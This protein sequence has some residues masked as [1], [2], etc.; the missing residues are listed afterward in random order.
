MTG[1]VSI[2][3]D[4]ALAAALAHPAQG[5]A[6]ALTGP[7][8]TGKSFALLQRARMLAAALPAGA[9]LL[10]APGDAGVARLR[11]ELAREPGGVAAESLAG[12]A[13]SILREARP[14]V[15]LDL[16]D[17]ATAATLFEEASG[18]LFSLEWPELATAEIDPE[19]TGL[20][21][22]QR[23]AASAFRL[24]A[25][26]R[27]ALVS[28]DAFKTSGLRGAT[29]FYGRPPNFASSEL[30]LDTAAKYRDSLRVSPAELDR[31][32]SREVDLVL[33][34]TRLYEGYIAALAERRVVTANDAIYDAAFLLH[35]RADL[36]EALRRRFPCA[37]IDDAQDL[38][39]AQLGLLSAIYGDRLTGVTLAG[40]AAQATRGF[41]AGAR[42][43][44]IFKVAAATITFS[45]NRRNGAA[46][47]R[48]AA[49]GLD[50]LSRGDLRGGGVTTYR[51]QD[52]R[53]EARFI[54]AGVERLLA[55]GI[56]PPEIAV[57]TR[58]LGCAHVY[59]DALLA[60]DV[61][62]D[63][64]GT[65]GLYEFPA[66]QDALAALWA[67]LD[68]FRHD[69][70]LRNLEAPWLRL[71][72]ASIAALCGEAR[73]PQPL[74]FDLPE[75]NEDA[76]RAG[77][78]DQK[79]DLRLG[80]NVTRG[81]VDDELPPESRER[82]V[83]FRAARERWASWTRSLGPSALARA[84]LA[85]S[86]LAT[87]PG[88]ARGRF[89]AG[90]IGRF[91]ERIEAFEAREPL[92]TLEDF[93]HELERAD[94]A[95]AGPPDVSCRDP[96]AVKILDVEAAKGASFEAVFLPDLRAGAWPRYYVPDAFLYL[97]S[98]GMIAKE[99][100]GD[101]SCSR[102]AKFTYASFRHKFRDKYNA[103]ERR[104]FSC[105]ASRARTQLFLCASGTP[106]RGTNTPELLGEIEKRE[107]AAW[108]ARE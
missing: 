71:C 55:D 60:R 3:A 27:A 88:G 81:D 37:A 102:T 56:A 99:N 6:L 7:A 67:A 82:L 2:D 63:V 4:A 87:L 30:L 19:I 95:D 46:I 90:L 94:E 84:I 20:R 45:T 57:I 89:E 33:V 92:G 70:L 47:E 10:C 22:P 8:G 48:T 11:A 66:V 1:A 42:G 77:R 49:F 62:V 72:D 85:E 16:I 14:G 105:A 39:G 104:A 5:D 103:E 74:L 29:K 23:F 61:P 35:E 86:A 40:D 18:A 69:Y 17:D 41:A 64:G 59:I 79:R 50:P 68:P 34:L 75:E 31:Q 12:L 44:E 106:T 78:W 25:K 83:A 107:A 97:P 28:P 108:S 101:A 43:G 26:L 58:H 93:L 21:S 15:P 9:V 91:V 53:D 24:I 32:R 13:L 52:G 100:V 65:I 96:D 36:R 98:M 76:A 51:A 73:D 38:T 80:R 54:L